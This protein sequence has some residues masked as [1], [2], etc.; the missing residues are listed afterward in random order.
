[1]AL[2][3]LWF[4]TECLKSVNKTSPTKYTKGIYL[5]LWAEAPT[6]KPARMRTIHIF[7]VKVEQNGWGESSC[8]RLSSLPGPGATH[9]QEWRPSSKCS[10][11]LRQVCPRQTC[12]S[13]NATSR[14]KVKDSE[15]ARASPKRSFVTNYLLA[16]SHRETDKSAISW[17]HTHLFISHRLGRG[18]I[19]SAP[20]IRYDHIWSHCLNVIYLACFFLIF[21]HF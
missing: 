16:E 4:L 14:S 18:A 2:N 3:N 5:Q 11:L 15:T 19:I 7:M 10:L 1:M 13:G 8:R 21:L 12:L 6:A 17:R 20:D 9:R